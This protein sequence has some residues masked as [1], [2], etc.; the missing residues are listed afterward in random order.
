[1]ATFDMHNEKQHIQYDTEIATIQKG[2]KDM[3]EH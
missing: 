2:Q 3:K 1:M